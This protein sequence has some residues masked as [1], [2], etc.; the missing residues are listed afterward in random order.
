LLS[1]EQKELLHKGQLATAIRFGKVLWITSYC[2]RCGKKCQV[3]QRR[4]DGAYEFCC[5]VVPENSLPVFVTENRLTIDSRARK[6]PSFKRKKQIRDEQN[7]RCIYCVRRFGSRVYS[8]GRLKEVTL[9][10]VW[11]HLIPFIY[12]RDNSDRNFVGACQICNGWKSD[13]L[14]CTV[15]EYREYLNNKWDHSDYREIQ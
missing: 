10:C 11:D 7:D 12:S 2:P 4:Q 13:I 9:R 14:K 1:K 8:I 15:Q 6:Q 3:D 5:T